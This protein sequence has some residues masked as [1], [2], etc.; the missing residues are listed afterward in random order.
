MSATVANTGVA[1]GLTWMI[2]DFVIKVPHT[3]AVHVSV[4]LP[5]QLPGSVLNVEVTVPERL[6]LPVNPL[7]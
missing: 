2:L 7:S 3:V 5:P 6:Q 4:T 1:A